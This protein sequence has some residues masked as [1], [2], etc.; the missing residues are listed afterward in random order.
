M[1]ASA[2]KW[3]AGSFEAAL[4]HRNTVTSNGSRS[5]RVD[6]I[7]S[8]TNCH[9]GDGRYVSGV[10][11][12]TVK[13]QANKT[14]SCPDHKPTSGEHFAR[15]PLCSG[16]GNNMTTIHRQPGNRSKR[17]AGRAIRQPRRRSSATA[18]HSNTETDSR[19]AEQSSRRVSS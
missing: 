11:R 19:L 4:S 17:L 16:S 3:L 2:N 18:R 7:N 8:T 12:R 13:H 6:W 15:Q 5:G 10:V 1:I 9:S 14:G